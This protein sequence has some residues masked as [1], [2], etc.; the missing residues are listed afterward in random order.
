MHSN[1]KVKRALDSDREI[2]DLVAAHDVDARRSSRIHSSHSTW[3]RSLCR[4]RPRLL[5]LAYKLLQPHCRQLRALRYLQ[6]LLSR[7]PLQQMR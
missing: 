7:I 2:E 1:L 4:L 6:W 3:P 5:L